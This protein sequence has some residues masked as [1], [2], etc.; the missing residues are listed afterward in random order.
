M[1]CC[2]RGG[3]IFIVPVTEHIGNSSQITQEIMMLVAPVDSSGS[4][5]GIIRYVQSFGSGMVHVNDWEARSKIHNTN[6]FDKTTSKAMFFIGWS[7]GT[8]DAYDIYPTE[9]DQDEVFFE[10]LTCKDLV[11]RLIEKLLLVNR[12]DPLIS[13]SLWRKAWD[14]CNKQKDLRIIMKGIKN[15]LTDDFTSTR[16]LLMSLIE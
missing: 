6:T 8:V 5:D 15:R 2:L 12:D 11:I 13:S 4:E 3:T 7:G 9:S 1:C 14:E 16:A 10:Q